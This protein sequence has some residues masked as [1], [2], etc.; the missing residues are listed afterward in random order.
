MKSTRIVTSFLVHNDK[1]LILKRSE[2]VK[3]MKGL[4]AGVSGIIEGNEEP[5]YRAKREILEEV[6]IEE[7]KITLLKSAQQIRTDSPQYENHEWLIFP[8]LFSVQD[9]TITLNWENQEYTWISPGELMQYQTVPSL[10]K[11]LASLL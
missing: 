7:N 1:Y 9:P 5:L 2:K 3:S 11:V 8:F 6:G 10:D 4:W